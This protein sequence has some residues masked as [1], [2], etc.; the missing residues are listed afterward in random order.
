MKL[1]KITT[2]ALEYPFLD[3]R[4]VLILGLLIVL[5]DLPGISRGFGVDNQILIFLFGIIGLLFG[6]YVL[7]YLY[8]VVQTSDRRSPPRFSN[9]VVT[10]KDGI[11][12]LY[13]ILV[14][15]LPALLVLAVV[16]F[17]NYSELFQMTYGGLSSEPLSMIGVLLGT[18]IWPGIFN[19]V[20]LLYNGSI[21]SG[22]YSLIAVVY[23]VIVIPVIFKA[24]R[25]MACTGELS[26]AFKV[27]DILT[28]M[29]EIGLLN[30]VLWYLTSGI[31]LI[32][33]LLV[34]IMV[35][36]IF[37]VLIHP[38]VGVVILSVTFVPYLYIFLARSVSL[39]FQ[40]KIDWPYGAYI[41]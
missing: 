10:M 28:S 29:R 9:H 25:C 39:A 35:T 1:G 16:S 18:M 40:G 24:I 32:I 17:L 41:L 33:L 14:Y 27:R 7:G 13:V 8:R 37:S 36:N 34:G 21:V 38:Q 2:D 4:R 22:I 12:T 19:L 3:V 15:L 6:I 5:S 31:L 20:G 11:K 23:I 30:I 26:S